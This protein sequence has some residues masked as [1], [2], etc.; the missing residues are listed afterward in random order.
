[1]AISP[2]NLKCD[3]KLQPT[4]T[5]VSNEQLRQ[6]MYHLW[7]G[8]THLMT[9]FSFDRQVWTWPFNL[10]EQ[11]AL[12]LLKDN[13]SNYFEIN[14]LMFNFGPD[15]LSL[16]PFYHLTFK[17]D[18]DLLPTWTNV[19]NSTSISQ[20]HQLCQIILRSLHKCTL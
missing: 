17:Y 8:Q 1:M 5:N 9:I 15:K 2:L 18:L 4:W 13:L 6:I 20:G 12:Q 19:S 11:M 3:L 7:S 10:P 16:W 14:A